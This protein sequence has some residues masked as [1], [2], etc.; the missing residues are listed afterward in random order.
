MNKLKARGVKIGRRRRVGTGL[1]QSKVVA[2][3]PN[4]LIQLV[5]RDPSSEALVRHA[6]AT[7]WPTLLD[8]L[9]KAKID[10]E[11]LLKVRGLP[12]TDDWVK[13]TPDGR[14]TRP[15]PDETPKPR[16]KGEPKVVWERGLELAMGVEDSPE[17]YAAQLL[18]MIDDLAAAFNQIDVGAKSAAH[19]SYELGRLLER[20]RWKLQHEVPALAGHAQAKKLKRI[21]PRGTESQRQKGEENY[22]RILRMAQK[23]C[24][25]SPEL[26]K[27]PYKLAESISADNSNR[28]RPIK[29][30]RGPLGVQAI[31]NHIKKA[32]QR[33]DLT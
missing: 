7:G 11:K 23:I 3:D 31:V 2:V 5:A 9:D 19:H 18:R 17:W 28:T 8:T 33:G 15:A 4:S 25:K 10:A 22:L 21:S 27:R 30:N 1:T 6:F 29:G 24:A 12:W 16:K 14:W 26:L 20:R 32:I 13:V